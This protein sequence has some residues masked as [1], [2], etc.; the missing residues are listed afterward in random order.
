MCI[1]PGLLLVCV[2][3]NV[4]QSSISLEQAR[5]ITDL[6]VLELKKKGNEEVLRK[7]LEECQTAAKDNPMLQFQLKMA[8]LIPKVMEILG[9]QI[10]TV[11][12]SKIESSQVMG[13]VV[14]I[15]GLSSADVHLG[16]QVTKIMKTLGGDFSGLYEEDEEGDAEEID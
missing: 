9:T 12:G 7:I 1:F 3:M 14:Q 2:N 6:A 16:I 15:Q 10:E 11:L 8:K 13:Y 5:R 4:Q